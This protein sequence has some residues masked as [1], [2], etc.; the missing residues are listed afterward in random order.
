MAFTTII[1]A[2][3]LHDLI[4]A[5]APL[6]VLDCTFDLT[7]PA[8]GRAV[9]AQGHIPGASYV[10]LEED[11]SGQ[12]DGANGRHPLPDRAA[13][14][15]HMRRLGL[16]SGQQV[17]A[18]DGNGG[19]FAA[20]LWWMLRW[21]GH[22]AVA[23]LDGGTAVWQAAGFTLEPGSTPAPDAGDFTP[24]APLVGAVVSADQVLA[25][26]ASGEFVVIDARDPARF[27]GEPH[28]LDTVSG[29]IPGAR[30]RF[31]RD[32]FDA[33]GKFLSPDRLAAAFRAVLDGAPPEKAVMQCGSGVTACSNALAMEIA[34][35]R[36]AGL[37]PGS[38]SE[39]TAD[40]ARPVQTG[41]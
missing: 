10:D 14:A 4:V 32:N 22:D 6:L 13:F 37:Y 11:L 12:P 25:N 3:A 20:R 23:V 7:D 15:Q 9:Y 28:P 21:L 2:D 24:G 30:N 31:L 41:A 17:I 16:N 40:P 38:W 34:G 35:L 8:K 19:H 1:S 18:Y 5:H 36:G 27:R 29:H 26:I 39:W 33:D